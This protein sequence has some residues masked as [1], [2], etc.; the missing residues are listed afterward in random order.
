AQLA[1]LDSQL[2]AAKKKIDAVFPH[3]AASQKKWE[4]EVA[5]G[6]IVLEELKP[7]S[8]ASPEEKKLAKNVFAALKKKAKARLAGDKETINNYYFSKA[9]KLAPADFSALAKIERERKAAA[10]AMPKCLVSVS[11]PTKR[12]VRILARGNWMDESG[13]IVHAALPHY[14]P[15]PKIE[16]REPTRLDLAQWLVSRDNPLTARVFVNRLWKQFF[17]IGI[18]KNLD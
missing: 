8:T 12:V 16:G 3:F 9:S 1:R 2:A 11:S 17:G 10:D 13:E 14:L 7:D 4:A 18:S 6:S 15:Q 5:K